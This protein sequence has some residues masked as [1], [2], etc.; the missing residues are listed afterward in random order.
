MEMRMDTERPPKNRVY[1]ECSDSERRIKGRVLLR[2]EAEISVELPS[3]FVLNMR[4]RRRRGPY[5]LRL[6]QL[7]FYSDG[8]PVT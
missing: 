2:Q 5:V 7:E 1:V 3:G 4:R 6:G 8:K